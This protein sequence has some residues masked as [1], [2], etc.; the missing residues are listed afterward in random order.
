MDLPM[1]NIKIL[2]KINN[3]IEVTP[4][5]L[6]FVVAADQYRQETQSFSQ[7][8][9][10]VKN[11]SKVEIQTITSE[12]IITPQTVDIEEIMGENNR[13]TRELDILKEKLAK[14]TPTNLSKD[15]T[16]TNQ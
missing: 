12:D 3:Y 1:S 7:Y 2:V 9:T 14:L 13:L 5:M 10:Y 6:S 16:I 15:Q 4:E 8:T 11:K